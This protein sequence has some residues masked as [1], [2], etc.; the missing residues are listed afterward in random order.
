MKLYNKEG[1]LVIDGE[2]DLTITRHRKSCINIEDSTKHIKICNFVYY[3]IP[4][5]FIKKLRLLYKVLK[6]IFMKG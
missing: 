2:K 4:P 5:G 3:M 6:F 1:Q